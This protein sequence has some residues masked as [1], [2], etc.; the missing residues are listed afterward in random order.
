[1]IAE[2]IENISSDTE[3]PMT[4]TLLFLADQL[5]LVF[6]KPKGRCYTTDMI[7]RAFTGYQKSTSCYVAIKRLFCLLS[8]RLLRDVASYFNVGCS[9]SSYNYLSNKVQYLKPS[10]LLVILQ[11][12]ET[13]MKPK[14]TYKC[15]KLIG[16]AG[17]NVQHQA[18]RIQ[19]FMISCCCL[20]TPMTL[21]SGGSPMFS[22]VVHQPASPSIWPAVQSL[23]R[24]LSTNPGARMWCI[25]GCS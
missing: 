6:A 20:P 21:A 3:D 16:N 2:S 24:G 10:K 1:M 9:N 14:L 23:R 18:N 22:L 19:C 13:H 12:D 7:I 4:H 5:R 25:Y 15:G 8:V 11:L 17:N